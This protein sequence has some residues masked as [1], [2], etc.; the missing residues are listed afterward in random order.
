M[1]DAKSRECAAW[2]AEQIK[3]AEQG[4]GE[5]IADVERRKEALRDI[6]YSE[7]RYSEPASNMGNS[8]DEFLTDAERAA[9]AQFVTD[10]NSAGME[11]LAVEP[12]E[13]RV[14]RRRDTSAEPETNSREFAP[15]AH[16]RANANAQGWEDWL[17]ARLEEERAH[18]FE[19]VG[20]AVGELLNDEQKAHDA[21]RARLRDRLR[22]VEIAL[23]NTKADVSNL[24]TL[25]LTNG[26]DVGVVDLPPWPSKRGEPKSVN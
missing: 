3:Y 2:V 20:M 17:A 23:A 26:K 19:M 18:V 24:R 11:A 4:R 21:E 25:L 15:T 10:G 1:D 13:P 8:Q 6:R 5:L 22:D 12:K 9:V 16:E 14:S 7:P